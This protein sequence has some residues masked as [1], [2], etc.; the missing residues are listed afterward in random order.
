MSW[1]FSQALVAEY[2]QAN[3][4]DGELFA[5]LR[6]TTMREAYCWRDKMTESLDL[7]QFGMTSQ[8]ST[9]GLGVE[10]LTWFR[11][12]FRARTYRQ[13]ARAQE[14]TAS[15]PACG[16]RWRELSV[17]Y[18]RD[19]C[20]WKTH[21]SL[22]DEDLSACSLTLPKWGSMR[23]GALLAHTMPAH[24]TSGNA[25][26]FLPTIATSDVKGRSGAGHIERHGPKRLSDAILFPTITVNGNNNCK[27]LSEKSG[28]GLA[29]F[30][31]TWPTPVT[32]RAAMDTGGYRSTD[33][34]TKPN[35]LGW[36]VA[37]KTPLRGR[38]NPEF[39]EWL[40]GWPIG[41]T[42][43]SPLAMDKFRA[44]WLAHSES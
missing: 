28:D 9:L 5:P 6:S 42:A 31:K 13:P 12:G 38:L 10:L 8:H 19:S 34:R 7:F 33:G 23:R 35:N 36:A 17:R 39:V 29:T 32:T 1:H 11:A 24:I 20:S 27:G 22:W 18:D 4:L 25:S 40:M 21:R 41:S 43:F 26:G 2:S 16:G 30:V 44:W 15:A 3:C 14:S 37:E